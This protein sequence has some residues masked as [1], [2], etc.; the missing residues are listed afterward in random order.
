MTGW[1]RG[2]PQAFDRRGEVVAAHQV[3]LENLFPYEGSVAPRAA[4]AVARA[5]SRR[6]FM[7]NLGAG[8]WSKTPLPS[9]RP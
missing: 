1:R 9:W 5:V 2:A 3:P 6:L 4:A 7:A 8:G